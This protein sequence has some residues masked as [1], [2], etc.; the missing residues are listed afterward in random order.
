MHFV[1]GLLCLISTVAT[2]EWIYLKASKA[3]RWTAH[4]TRWDT[5]AMI[6]ISHKERKFRRELSS[7]E[8]RVII[9]KW[10]RRFKRLRN[11]AKR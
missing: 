10:F 6:E 5:F 1:F 4:P 7:Q 11:S 3:V 2:V 8:T 9:E